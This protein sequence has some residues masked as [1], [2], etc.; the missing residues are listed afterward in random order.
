MKRNKC[1]GLEKY[2]GKS[3]EITVD[4]P[5]G[6]THPKNP[7]MVYP[8]N[9]GYLPGVYGGD[10][11]E[12]DVY[13][14]GVETPLKEFDGI[15]AGDQNIGNIKKTKKQKGKSTCSFA[16]HYSAIPIYK[17]FWSAE[18]FFQKRFCKNPPAKG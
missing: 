17:V 2:L 14:L 13:I 7:D 1:Q 6:S 15:S 18:P 10:G 5:L 12:Q 16:L 8:V 9:Y 11:E 3:V 4:R